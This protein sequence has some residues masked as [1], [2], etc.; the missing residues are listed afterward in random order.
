MIACRNCGEPVDDIATRCPSCGESLL[1]EPT[2]DPASRSAFKYV[3]AAA[4]AAIVV[5][6]ILLRRPPAVEPFAE[7]ARQ[8]AAVARFERLVLAGRWE[9]LYPLVAEPPAPDAAGF[10]A[11]MRERVEASGR[12]IS[13]SLE[14]LQLRRSSSVP[15]L[16]VR[17]S[18]RVTHR[19]EVRAEGG[20]SVFVW[21]G[22]RWLFAFTG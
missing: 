7:P 22:G 10:A 21:H 15:V 2:A 17:H 14:R 11:L 5:A 13:I 8:R 20:E 6:S 9:E 18:V 19:G 3:A 1:G 4:V 12:I 16:E